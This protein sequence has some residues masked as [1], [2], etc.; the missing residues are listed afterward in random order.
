MSDENTPHDH[1]DPTAARLRAALTAEAAMVQPDDHLSTIRERTEDGERP[2]WRH[3]AALAVA[4]AV[5]LGLAVGGGA[6]VLGGG[7][8]PTVV[9]GGKG[10]TSAP[11][12][13]TPESPSETPSTSEGTA[14]PT[15]AVPVEGNVF[16][17]YAMA[18]GK[19]L[20]LYREERP[21]IGM[22]PATMAL[23]TMFAEPALDPD[24]AGTWPEGTAVTGYSTKGD[25]ATVDL[26]VPEGTSLDDFSYQQLVY[27]VTA[28]DSAVTSVRA[29]V[30]GE[31][32]GP[33]TRAPR[34]EVQGLIW[35]LSP[36]QGST[37]SSPV[38]ITGYGTAFE[39]TISWEVRREGSDEVVADGFT[40]G[41]SM[42]EFADFS[43]S[44]ELDPG[45]YELRAFESSAENGEP[46]H[47]DTKTFTVE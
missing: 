47:V 25:V 9:A 6:A 35:L 5:V 10:S 38:G 29:R 23:T 12:S 36:S 30:N 40:Q 41:G 13:S 39:G 1:D 31:S 43:D 45:T 8:D 34:L 7:D 21:N 32:T 22:D 19:K 11:P 4:A 24:Y 17:Y 42:G 37:V 44:V 15:S 2:W 14:T 28:N 27:T 3:P 46:I 18:D 26:D 16:V 33:I 20:R